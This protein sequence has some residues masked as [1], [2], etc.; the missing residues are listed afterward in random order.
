MA[1]PGLPEFLYNRAYTRRYRATGH[2]ILGVGHHVV[3]VVDGAHQERKCYRKTAGLS[4]AKQQRQVAT[5]QRKQG[6]TLAHLEP[7]AIP[8]EFFIQ[9]YPLAPTKVW[10]GLHRPTALPDVFG[11]NNLVVE[12][13]TGA[14]LLID[15]VSLHAGDPE[16]ASAYE[17]ARRILER[18]VA[19]QS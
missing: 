11:I 10:L 18:V 16:D 12:V 7:F 1:T 14:I 19:S 8:Q 3:T 4:E 13:D 15:P 6:S 5:M 17:Q 2:E 9:E